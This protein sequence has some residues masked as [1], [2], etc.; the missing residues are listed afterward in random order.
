MA[1]QAPPKSW[2]R[3]V[4]ENVC[5]DMLKKRKEAPIPF[6]QLAEEDK[7]DPVELLEEKD[8]R[9]LVLR[10]EVQEVLESLSP[11]HQKVLVYRFIEGLSHK[12]IARGLS[13]KVGSVKVLINKAKKAFKKH[14]IIGK[15]HRMV[16]R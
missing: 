4:A 10:C 1:V 16:R 5:R 8:W 6:S 12:E 14:G 13:C 2:L 15:E 11:T 3:K 7:I 9:Q